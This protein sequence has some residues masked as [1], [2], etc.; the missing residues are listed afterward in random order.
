MTHF[1]QDILRQPQELERTLGYLSGGG[2]H[3][4][5]TAAATIRRRRHAYPTGNASRLQA[6]L[7]AADV[8]SFDEDVVGTLRSAAAE[9]NYSMPNWEAQVAGTRWCVPG[10]PVQFV[11][12]GGSVGGCHDG[13][14]AGEEAV[15][16]AATSL[17]AGSSR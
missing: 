10:K 9:T 15:K 12:R 16:V 5:Q 6:A 1:L 2:R 14:L 11:A 13:R 7:V 17:G 4:L 3:G 8:A